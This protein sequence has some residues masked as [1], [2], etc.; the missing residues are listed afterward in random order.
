MNQTILWV[1][2][3]V[4]VTCKYKFTFQTLRE[5]FQL[6]MICS[7]YRVQ[8]VESIINRNFCC[9]VFP[10]PARPPP[11]VRKRA[12]A[13]FIFVILSTRCTR[14]LLPFN[15]SWRYSR[16]VCNVNLHINLLWNFTSKLKIR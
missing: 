16:I 2:A 5:Y 14:S 11:R 1:H 7:K 6:R 12:E 8:R 4:S 13:K 9:C 10:H 15:L 3:F